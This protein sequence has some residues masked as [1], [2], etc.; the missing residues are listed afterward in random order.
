M[1]PIEQWNAMTPKERDYTILMEMF[2]GQFDDYDFKGMSAE[3]LGSWLP[4]F[5][6]NVI[7]AMEAEEKIMQMSGLIQGEYAANLTKV[8]EIDGWKLTA[9]AVLK[10][11]HASAA[12]RCAAMYL[13]LMQQKE[14]S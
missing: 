8:L 4:Q 1:T 9:D 5:T 11:V 13:T 12:D 2:D 10:L 14:R 7:L 6:A 3:K